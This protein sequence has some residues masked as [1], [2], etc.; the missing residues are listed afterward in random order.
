MKTYPILYTSFILILM[1]HACGIS[2]GG[3]SELEA[4]RDSLKV[5]SEKQLER[6]DNY[7]KAISLLNSTLDSIAYEEKMM[8]INAGN[9][10][11]PVTKDIVRK[12]LERFE[13]IL[14]QQKARITQLESQ[15]KARN[16][17]SDMS[18]ALITHLQGQIRVK[19]TQILQLKKEIE[20]KNVDI[21]HLQEQVESQQ[22]TIDS[23]TVTIDELSK[24]TQRQNEALARQ[25]AILNNGYVLL[26]TKADLQR[27]GI[28]KKGKLVAESILDRSKF[29][30]VDMRNWKEVSFTAKKPRI[31]SNMPASSY[32]LTT[33]GQGNFNL[34]IINPSDFWKITS[35]LIIQTD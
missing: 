31:L 1:L 9:V 20:K 22:Y 18:L 21:S 26:G 34:N 33:D 32:E 24:R 2:S 5:V 15:I 23:Q 35:Y 11:G 16:D 19:D 28:M 27:K 4:E 13:A 3:N 30:Q 6:L 8:F 14:N 10:E 29:K 17:S 25:D 7:E 12:N